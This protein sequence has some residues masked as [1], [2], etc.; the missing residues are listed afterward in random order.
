MLAAILIE[1]TAVTHCWPNADSSLLNKGLKAAGAWNLQDGITY[2]EGKS[3]IVY[4][5]STKEFV[6]SFTNIFDLLLAENQTFLDFA[7]VTSL[8]LMTGR[9]RPCYV[10]QSPSLL[11]D[12]YSQECFFNEISEYDCPL[13]I[14]GTSETSYLQQIAGAP[15]NV[16]YYKIAEY[17]Y[18]N[19]RPLVN[20][21]EFSIW[22][23]KDLWDK[24]HSS[25]QMSGFE[26]NGYTL[27]DYGYDFTT[28]YTDE[29]GN[30]Q[31]TFA[32]Y[33]TYDL[34]NIPYIWANYDEYNAIEN[35]VITKIEPVQE[36]RYEFAGSQSVV[37]SEGV[38]IAYEATN[39]S[40]ADISID[41]VLYD[42]TS[43]NEGAKA[44]N[45]F[46]VKPGTNQ[47][48]VRASEDY[49]WEA[50]NIDTILFGSNESI[51]IQNVRLLEG[52]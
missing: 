31:F 30:T 23:E 47:Y 18:N 32:P 48:L 15:H 29:N 24:Y 17:V 44:Q 16:R 38:Y 6:S 51:S 36:N 8:Y 39:K 37:S 11:T 22:C 45:F 21:G 20:F 26:E 27:V 40:E 43:E 25:L 1:A 3:R 7:N 13:A 42:S 50:F 5:D 46:V 4:D 14:V 10:G 2:N 41:I 33:H 52:D 34:S 28:S 12:L 49:F 9:T 19:Y 35:S